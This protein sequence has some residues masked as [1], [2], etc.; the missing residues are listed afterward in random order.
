MR[1]AVRFATEYRY[2]EQVPSSQHLLRVIPRSTAEQR[3]EAVA[4]VFEPRP[5]E[6]RRFDDFWGNDVVLAGLRAPHD[7]LAVVLAAE[8]AVDRVAPP[9]DAGPAWETVAAAAIADDDLGPQAPAHQR[10]ATRLTP[11]ADGLRAYAL[12]SFPPGR[13]AWSGAIDLARRIREDFR[14]APGATSPATTARQAFAQRSGVCQDFAHVMIAA[15]RGLGLPAAYVSGY[16]RTEP[17]PGQ[18]RLAGADAMHAWVSV[19]GGPA[20]G[21]AGFDPT[22]ALVVGDAHVE[23]AIGRDY[24]DVAPVDGVIVA[25]GTH[26]FEVGVDVAPLACDTADGSGQP[27]LPFAPD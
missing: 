20:L 22:N 16:L 27:A 11:P 5:A 13:P 23:V 1:Y 4:L 24:A 17:P 8:V 6:Q 14:Y 21:W 15:L 7:R 19:W 3:V 9:V 10:F 26:D 25:A 18:P 12:A 2:G